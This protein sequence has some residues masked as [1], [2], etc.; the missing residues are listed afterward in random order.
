MAWTQRPSPCA[1]RNNMSSSRHLAPT[2]L[3]TWRQNHNRQTP[4][5]P[6]NPRDDPTT[7]KILKFGWHHRQRVHCGRGR[8]GGGEGLEPAGV[9][10]LG[11]RTATLRSA[12][13]VSTICCN[14]ATSAARSG[15]AQDRAGNTFATSARSFD[16]R[17]WPSW[18]SNTNLPQTS[19]CV[20]RRILPFAQL[21]APTGSSCAAFLT[22]LSAS[23]NTCFSVPSPP[24]RRWL[25]RLCL[26][27]A[28]SAMT[29]V[30]ER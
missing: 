5:R 7:T 17:V 23:C 18:S 16:K 6:A 14:L 11:A 4:T 20:A 12:V 1:G 29:S 27:F 30:L 15:G 10:D 3:S 13:R 22:P 25:L 8:G 2:M 24:M 9:M 19:S 21:D 28:A 26:D